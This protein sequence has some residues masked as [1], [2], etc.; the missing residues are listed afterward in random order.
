MCLAGKRVKQD[1][2]LEVKQ[3]LSIKFDCTEY[4]SH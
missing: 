2:M 1:Q 4:G 3:M